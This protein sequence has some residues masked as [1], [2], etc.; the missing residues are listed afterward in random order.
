MLPGE[1]AAGARVA[2][3]SR[4]TAITGV[5]LLA[6]FA[7]QIVTVV[8]G[9]TSVLAAHVVIGT[10]LMPVVGVKILSTGWR[11]VHYYRGDRDVRRAGP[12]RMYFRIL[13]PLL[14]ILTVVLLASGSTA[15]LGTG[16]WASAA[17]LAHKATFY[18]WLIAVSMHAVPHYSRAV[19]LAVADTFRRTGLRVSGVRTRR[20]VLL[21]ALATGAGLA[22]LMARHCAEFLLRYSG[23][24]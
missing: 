20:G 23:H 24:L 3:N 10:V 21:A 7:A 14:T 13:G 22:P 2:G 6:L 16:V 4:L 18:L 15:F 11:I 17:L 8:L 1:A 9:V 5:C 12:P 19:R